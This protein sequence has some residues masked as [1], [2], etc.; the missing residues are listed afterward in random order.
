MKKISSIL[1]LF[2]IISHCSL[3]NKTGI[4]KEKENIANKDQNLKLEDVFVK[5]KIFDKEIILRGNIKLEIDKPLKTNNYL[6]RYFTSSNNIPNIYYNNSNYKISKFKKRIVRFPKKLTSNY[7]K[8]VDILL[9]D[10]NLISFDHNGT[11][12]VYS[13][14]TGKKILEYNFYKKK[15]KKFKK[16]LYLSI[17]DNSLYVAD[18]IGYAYSIDLDK[19]KLIWAKNFGVPFRSNIKSINNQIF[20]ANQDNIIYALTTNSGETVWQFS[21]SPTTLKTNFINNIAIDEGNNEL[22]FLNTSG[23]LYAFDFLRQKIKWFLNVSKSTFND[24]SDLFVAAPIVF[25]NNNILISTDKKLKMFNT[26]FGQIKW[27]K[28]FAVSIKPTITKNNVFLITSNNILV[29]LD[30][31]TGEIIWSKKIMKLNENKKIKNIKKINHLLIANNQVLLFSSTG[32]LLTYNYKNGNLISINKILKSGMMNYPII[33]DG[34]MFILDKKY[35]LTI[36]E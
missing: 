20:L 28:K 32:Y 9:K 25:K 21:T 15:Y 10:D 8:T 13:F 5:S 33:S 36:F 31:I 3:D 24:D 11:I 27:E 30:I 35:K 7:N 2:I 17:K 16:I 12:F 14:E 29:C 23:E 19:N 18:N 22:F 6:E 26:T 34:K 1:F 4:W